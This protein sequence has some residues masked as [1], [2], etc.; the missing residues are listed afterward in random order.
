VSD[1][2]AMRLDG[3]SL[4]LLFWRGLVWR[5]F[6][7][8]VLWWAIA[9]TRPLALPFAAVGVLG[10]A[11]AS[12]A[13]RPPLRWRRVATL[14]LVGFFALEAVRA[15][16]DVARRALDPRVR[17][18]PSFVDYEMESVDLYQ[19]VLLANLLSLMPG[20]LTCELDGRFLRVHV[21]TP[22]GDAV[23]KIAEVE[24]RVR[25]ALEGAPE[26]ERDPQ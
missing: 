11:L 16:T 12:V 17:V 1:R 15:G 5:L 7:F 8:S 13:L 21:L 23:E 14:R 4:S 2:R 22:R 6:A 24:R 3:S 19:Q 10:A 26:Q 20:T 25:A 18:R 9:E